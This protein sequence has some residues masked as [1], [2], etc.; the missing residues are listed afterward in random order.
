MFVIFDSAMELALSLEKLNN[1][2]LLNLH[3]VITLWLPIYLSHPPLLV[4]LFSSLFLVV[5]S[6][7]V[8]LLKMGYRLFSTSI[9]LDQTVIIGEGCYI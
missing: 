4:L 2:K 6:K 3:K 5:T 7:Y 9:I 1:E 8:H